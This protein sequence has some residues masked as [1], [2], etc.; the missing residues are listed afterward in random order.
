MTVEFAGVSHPGRSRSNNED[1]LGWNTERGIWLVADGMGGHASGEVASVIVRDTLLADAPER[2]LAG[3]VCDAHQAIMEAAGRDD[4]LDG[5]GSTVVAVQISDAVGHFVWVGD[6]RAYM[7]RRGELKRVTRDHSFIELLRDRDHLTEAQLRNHPNRNVVTQTLGL[8]E[9]KPSV[10]DVSFRS[11]DVILLCSDGLNDELTD[12]EI[13][14]V[15]RQ[16][17]APESAARHLID[18]ALD[19]GGRDNVSVIVLEYVGAGE[20]WWRPLVRR[21]TNWLATGTRKAG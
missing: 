14:E 12:E 19:R 17:R 13:A 16:N 21:V 2:D 10:V 20:T 6:S 5:M 7:L 18:D 1:A 8:G 4:A 3:L 9:P 15:L 11:G